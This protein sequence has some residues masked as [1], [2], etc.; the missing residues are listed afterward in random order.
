MLSDLGKKFYGLRLVGIPDLFE[1]LCWA[2]M[3][4]QV[5]LAFAYKL[6]QRLTETFGDSLEW[7]G[8]TYRLFPLPDEIAGASLSDLCGLQLTKMKAAAI[9]EAADLMQRGVLSRARLLSLGSFDAAQQELLRIRGVGPWTAHYV[10]MRCLRDPSAFP[11]GDAGLRNAVKERLAL[12]RKPTVRELQ[13]LFFADWTG[14][15][16]YATFFC[17]GGPYTNLYS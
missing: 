3:G 9:L 14:W 15:E 13:A 10:R 6:K 17:C 2:I 1:A 11:I 8:R 7:D 4:Q 12:G 5:N 16:A